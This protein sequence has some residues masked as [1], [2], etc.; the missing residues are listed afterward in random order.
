VVGAA[1]R[2]AMMSP[3]RGGNGF[4]APSPVQ[5]PPP[6]ALFPRWACGWPV[7]RGS[8]QSETSLSAPWQLPGPVGDP[9]GRGGAIHWRSLVA[10]HQPGTVAGLV[11]PVAGGVGFRA[12]GLGRVSVATLTMSGR[13]SGCRWDQVLVP[14]VR[15]LPHSRSAPFPAPQRA[16]SALP[17]PGQALP[18][19]R[20]ACPVARRTPTVTSSGSFI[21]GD[22]ER[23][24]RQPDALSARCPAAAG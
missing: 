20:R 16:R 4:R 23:Q 5:L 9:S 19:C 10:V 14:H 15:R 12:E 18:A 7:T 3:R 17:N 8:R 24:Q 13:F 6:A 11:G 2:D 21:P 1:R 22:T